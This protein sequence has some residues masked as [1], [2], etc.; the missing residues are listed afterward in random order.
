MYDSPPNP[1]GE[2]E[3]GY[4]ETITIV[5]PFLRDILYNEKEKGVQI[6]DNE[7]MLKVRYMAGQLL[8]GKIADVLTERD[9]GDHILTIILKL[10]HT[11]DS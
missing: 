8:G 11:E 2:R 7:R 6:K 3:N 10:A 5:L 4:K 9:L 1:Q